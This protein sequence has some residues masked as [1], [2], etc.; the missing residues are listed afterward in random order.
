[1]DN[2][3]EYDVEFYEKESGEIPCKKFIDSLPD[4]LRAKVYR[5]IGLLVHNGRNLR[6]PY[7]EELED[8][9]FELRTKQSSN[10]T[11]CFYF[12]LVGKKAILTNGF[13][14]KT[15]KVPPGEIKRAKNYRDDYYRQH[16]EEG[17]KK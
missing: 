3:E 11:R 6:L 8:G 7:S 15:M 1:M 9:I 4:K 13:R 12:F 17:G 10:I 2:Q 5:D 14:K 16:P